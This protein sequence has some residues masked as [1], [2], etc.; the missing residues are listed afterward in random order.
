MSS[1]IK[2]HMM[3]LM[4]FVTQNELAMYIANSESM[5]W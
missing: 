1:S 5:S 2:E 4:K 3:F